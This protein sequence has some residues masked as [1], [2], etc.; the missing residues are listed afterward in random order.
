[1]I[2]L[3]ENTTLTDDVLRFA[4]DNSALVARFG[5]RPLSRPKTQSRGRPKAPTFAPVSAKP[6][7]AVTP[8]ATG[9]PPTWREAYLLACRKRNLDP[10]EAVAFFDKLALER[11]N[12]P[13]PRIIAKRL[14]AAACL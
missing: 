9:P 7:P 4:V 11:P 14:R 1:L 5:S 3:I 10:V 13:V 8:P 6:A 2:D 12:D